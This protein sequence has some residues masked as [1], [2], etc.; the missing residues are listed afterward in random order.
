MNAKVLVCVQA[1]LEGCAHKGES[2]A[3]LGA[4]L[5]GASRRQNQCV[6]N[7]EILV[8]VRILDPSMSGKIRIDEFVHFVF[9]A[10][11]QPSATRS[12]LPSPAHG[13]GASIYSPEDSPSN[14]LVTRPGH[15]KAPRER[16]LGANAL[17]EASTS[18][19]SKTEEK[20]LDPWARQRQIDNVVIPVIIFFRP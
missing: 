7:D 13:P 17:F 14:G 4:S 8:L 20:T 16:E 11:A 6:G 9:N 12:K 1:L 15:G 18:C 3:A 19:T 5:H 10:S 2:G